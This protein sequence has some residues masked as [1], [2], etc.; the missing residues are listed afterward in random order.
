MRPPWCVC[1]RPPRLDRIVGV[2]SLHHFCDVAHVEDPGISTAG[3]VEKH[4]G[5]GVLALDV[6]IDALAVVVAVVVP[7]PVWLRLL[8]GPRIDWRSL[9]DEDTVE[10][11][12]RP[13]PVVDE[14][15]THV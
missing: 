8:W 1:A 9:V 12:V 4:F 11:G 15:G 6:A 14:R 5:G 2:V 3:A 10:I 13:E 7:D